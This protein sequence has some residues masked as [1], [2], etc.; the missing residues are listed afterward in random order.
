MTFFSLGTNGSN[1]TITGLVVG[2]SLLAVL[3]IIILVVN[4]ILKGRKHCQ[5]SSTTSLAQH[6]ASKDD[7]QTFECAAYHQVMCRHD[8]TTDEES[9]ATDPPQQN[10]VYE[11][12]Q[13]KPVESPAD[14]VYAVI[15]QV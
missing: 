9:H 3:V 1:A 14:H 13:P 8:N 11:N 4:L 10:S 7:I 2:V 15:S 12:M 5:D 6:N